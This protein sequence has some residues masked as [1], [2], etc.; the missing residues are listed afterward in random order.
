MKHFKTFLI[1][2]TIN[3]KMLLLSMLILKEEHIIEEPI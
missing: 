3:R 1:C 2:E